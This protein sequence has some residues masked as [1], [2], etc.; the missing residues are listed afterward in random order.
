MD[1]SGAFTQLKV[2]SASQEFLTINTLKGLYRYKR[3]PFGVKTALS[4]LGYVKPYMDDILIGGRTLSECEENVIKV[5]ERLVDF[6]VKVNRSKCIFFEKEIEYLGYRFS[7][8]GIAQRTIKW[9]L[10]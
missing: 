10:Y 6:N 8:Q 1:L 9:M 2:S 7:G 3:L 5:F 4:G